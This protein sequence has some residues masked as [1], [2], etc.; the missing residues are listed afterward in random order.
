MLYYV[1]N[2]ENQKREKTGQT[3]PKTKVNIKE[4]QMDDILYAFQYRDLSK[5]AIMA[6]ADAQLYLDHH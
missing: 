5:E 2:K 3:R 6:M 4:K 1:S